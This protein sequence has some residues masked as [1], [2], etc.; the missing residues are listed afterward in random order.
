MNEGI[1]RYVKQHFLE[2]TRKALEAGPQHGKQCINNRVWTWVECDFEQS[3]KDQIMRE[4]QGELNLKEEAYDIH[5]YSLLGLAFSCLPLK[6]LASVASALNSSQVSNVLWGHCLLNVHGIPSIVASI[7]FV[8]PDDLL[9]RGMQALSALPDVGPYQDPETC[10]TSSQERHTPP[11]PLHPPSTSTLTPPKS[12]WVLYLQSQT[13]WFLPTLDN[14]RLIGAEVSSAN[15]PPQFVLASDQDSLPPWRPGRGSGV[16]KSS[17]EPVFV[18]KAHVL[19]EAFLR[20]C[21]RDSGKRIGAFSLA[22]VGYIEQY[23]DDDGLLDT[24]QLPEPF[25]TFHA[26]LRA[27]K[28][29]VRQW[30]KEFKQAL[31]LPEDEESDEDESDE[32]DE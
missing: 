26:Q 30:T 20:L 29:P 6:V 27:G 4:I 2:P 10:P 19:L 1:A 8:I 17:Q 23:V 3:N 31:H 22:M 5:H 16:F 7:D 14:T 12:Q 15:L 28:K 25:K 18:P 32:S 13:L 21:A 9:P 24:T 11:P